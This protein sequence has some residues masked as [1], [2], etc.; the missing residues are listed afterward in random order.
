MPFL[1]PE[2]KS[3][4][5]LRRLGT[6]WF[7]YLISLEI[8]DIFQYSGHLLDL[9]PW[10]LGWHFPLLISSTPSIVTA[11]GGDDFILTWM[12]HHCRWYL[13]CG[14]ATSHFQW[15]ISCPFFSY[16]HECLHRWALPSSQN[17]NSSNLNY[18]KHH[19]F[20]SST[21]SYFSRTWI[22]AVYILLLYWILWG[23]DANILLPLE[24]LLIIHLLFM[25]FG[26]NFSAVS[27]LSTLLLFLSISQ[28]IFFSPTLLLW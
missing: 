3:L 15:S 13:T 16:L 9:L 24:M 2:S 23:L 4:H 10:E 6:I 11:W 1:L 18:W 12:I 28:F 21:L 27:I 7:C 22:Y 17:D 8:I 14:W 25:L 19:I 20:S 26:L 5:L